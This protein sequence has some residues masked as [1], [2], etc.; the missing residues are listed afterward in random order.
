MTDCVLEIENGI[1][2][3]DEGIKRDEHIVGRR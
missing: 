3:G 1:V 2:D